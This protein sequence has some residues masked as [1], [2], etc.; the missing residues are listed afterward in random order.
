ME[1]GRFIAFGRVPGTTMVARFFKCQLCLTTDD[2]DERAQVAQ[3]G[4]I[5]TMEQ[6]PE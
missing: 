2:A 6:M 5:E 3:E 4:R 1:R